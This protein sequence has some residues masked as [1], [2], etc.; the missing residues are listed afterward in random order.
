MC[1]CVCKFGFEKAEIYAFA[2]ARFL[3][4]AV[5]AGLGVYHKNNH[6]GSA[7]ARPAP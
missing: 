3:E 2:S 7:V 6:F 5:G 4:V 1:V